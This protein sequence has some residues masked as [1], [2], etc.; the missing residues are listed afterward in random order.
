MV[1]LLQKPRCT[2]LPRSRS[3]IA[4]AG[5][6]LFA[7]QPR[8]NLLPV[9][10][11]DTKD[12]VFDD[13]AP[14]GTTI[15]AAMRDVNIE[16]KKDA[17]DKNPKS[18][19]WIDPHGSEGTVDAPDMPQLALRFRGTEQMSIKIKW[20]LEVIYDRPRG[21]SPDEQ[22][23]KEQ[24]EVFIPKKSEGSQ[25]WKEEVL[26]GAVKFFD[27][28]DWNTEL[29]EKGF[30]GGEAKLTYQLLK[31]DGG[32]LGSEETMLFSIRGKNPDPA[33][34]K[35]YIDDNA[36]SA[37]GNMWF[38][39]AIAKSESSAFNPERRYN[40]F[41]E[42]TGRYDKRPHKQGEPTWGHHDEESA[43]GFGLFQVTGRVQNTPQGLNGK[44]Y[45]IDRQDIWN[46]QK[47]VLAGLAI[48]RSKQDAAYDGTWDYM[49]GTMPHREK[50]GQPR[51]QRP[52]AKKSN[53]G[54]DVPVLDSGQIH[55]VRG[56][57]FED[58]SPKT[59]EAAVSMK[60]YNGAK[61]HYCAWDNVTKTW[62]FVPTNGKFNYVDRVCQEIE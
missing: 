7:A 14:Q 3:G 28:P 43:G 31:A 35:D 6:R 49:N 23:I 39:Y 60:A 56:V 55:T 20:K 46:W 18:I 38:A 13:L 10:L 59:I 8:I 36:S 34:C 9:E 11:V 27:H 62:K 37:H 5:A 1:A 25:P 50:A 21:N 53:N 45:N 12:K 29:Q 22:R 4:R 16:P 32:A 19:A 41:W 47:H 26:T 15:T 54:V 48:I 2:R 42:R 24:D 33:K 57:R 52:Q 51:G 17:D 61:R 40:Q 30:F 58:G 44:F